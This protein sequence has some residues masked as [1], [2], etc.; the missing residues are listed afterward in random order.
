MAAMTTTEPMTT[1]DAEDEAFARLGLER[2]PRGEELPE[3]DGL[4]MD[5]ERQALQM[6]LLLEPLRLYFAGRDVYVGKNQIIY[7][8]VEQVRNRDFLGPDV[9][10]VLDVPD[11]ERRSWVIWEEGKAPDVVVEIL[12]P[13]TAERDRGEKKSIYQDNIG[14][15]EYF[16][17]D[18]EG[19]ELAGFVLHD[20]AYVPIER[21]PAGALPCPSLDLALI[22]W[23]GDYMGRGGPWLRWAT[24]EGTPLPTGVEAERQRADEEQRRADEERRRAEQAERDLAEARALLER[25]R[26]QFGEPPR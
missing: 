15:R 19:G 23:D 14:V 26:E 25:Y 11:R 17:F 22:I 18:P 9:Y 4:P 2:P 3:T 6:D 21:E 5:S 13:K 24:Q 12:S 16:W 8:S 20:R 1:T 7:Y 10:V